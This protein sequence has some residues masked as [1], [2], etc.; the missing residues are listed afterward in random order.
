MDKKEF[1]KNDIQNI[2]SEN[3]ELEKI[4]GS[5][6]LIT[7]GTGLIGSMLVRTL[8]ILSAENDWGLSITAQIRD[9]DKAKKML[10]DVIKNNNIDFLEKDMLSDLEIG[11]DVDYIIHT[12][13]PTKSNFFITRPVETIQA[14]VTGTDNIMK[15]AV[16]K[17]CRSVVYLS[18]MEVYGEI[19][20]ENKLRK[21]DVGYLDPL[22]PRSSY[23]MSK[24]MAESICM[25]YFSEYGVPVKIVRLA[26]TFGFGIPK[27]DNRVFAQFLNSAVKN[28]DIVLFT[29]GG[30]KHMYLDTMDAVSAILTILI[31][32]KNGEVYNAA[33]EN[34]Y[35][36]IK[37]MGE[38]VIKSFGNGTG[39]LRIDTSKNN[40]QY[41]PEHMLNLDTSELT[42]LGWKPKYDLTDMYHRMND[43]KNN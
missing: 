24:R 31:K 5:H 34:T 29:R 30:S 12:A 3:A 19:T 14:I 35:L 40:G 1:L 38:L 23:P 32:G 17:Q 27:D 36:S 21:E 20:H 7:G 37:E 10:A 26:Q 39:S 2:L 41:P 42:A 11:T 25:G 33:N 18:S 15:L 16:Q 6:I 8:S 4:K 43:Y 9:A 28:E 22:S 13:A